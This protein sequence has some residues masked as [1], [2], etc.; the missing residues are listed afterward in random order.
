MDRH[1][2]KHEI[3]TCKKWRRVV[4]KKKKQNKN[5][6]DKKQTWKNTLYVYH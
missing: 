3:N 4:K 2:Y 5:L 6:K 1:Q